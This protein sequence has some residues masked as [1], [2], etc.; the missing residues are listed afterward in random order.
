VAAL[1]ASRNSSLTPNQI[2]QVL[3]E[4]VKP[5]GALSGKLVSPGI[6]DANAALQHPSVLEI[7]RQLPQPGAPG[8]SVK[9]GVMT[10]SMASHEAARYVVRLSYL[11]ARAR[12]GAKPKV[13]VVTTGS[14]TL[15]VKK[16]AKG[17]WSIS[18][19]LV[20][21]NSSV[22]NSPESPARKVKA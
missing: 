3:L 21:I 6:V 18:Y 7:P 17:S 14:A 1:I 12:K 2:K 22:L 20:S 15:I 10:I 4:T 19:R 13:K 5:L 16:V 11:P 8:V 9:K